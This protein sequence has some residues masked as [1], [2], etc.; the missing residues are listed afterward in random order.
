[1]AGM[2]ADPT[3]ELTGP[4]MTVPPRIAVFAAVLAGVFVISFWVGHTY[5]PNP[6]I[7]VPHSEP[8]S[9]QPPPHGSA[10]R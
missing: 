4:A 2:T 7:A 10:E 3:S 8:T 9:G 1:M 5:G 6:D